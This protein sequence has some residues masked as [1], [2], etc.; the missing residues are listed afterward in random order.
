MQSIYLFQQQTNSPLS[1]FQSAD[2]ANIFSTKIFNGGTEANF[3]RFVVA[4]EEKMYRFPWI[5]TRE[6]HD[7]TKP[8]TIPFSDPSYSSIKRTHN[9]ELKNAW[10]ACDIF[11][12]MLGVEP[13]TCISS[14]R[15]NSLLS[16]REKLLNSLDL[17]EGFYT[18]NL[19]ETKIFFDKLL[20]NLHPISTFDRFDILVSD[21]QQILQ[22]IDRLDRFYQRRFHI[23][24]KMS[25][26]MII[27]LFS[28]KLLGSNFTHARERLQSRVKNEVPKQQERLRS[29]ENFYLRHGRSE[30]EAGA[31]SETEN[32]LL[33]TL[34]MLFRDGKPVPRFEDGALVEQRPPVP[35]QPPPPP[36]F[37]SSSQS[38]V[39]G[40]GSTAA[41]SPGS[42]SPFVDEGD[43]RAREASFS[44]I[45]IRIADAARTRRQERR[46]NWTRLK[47]GLGPDP[48]PLTFF[49]AVQVVRDAMSAHTTKSSLESSS[50][51]ISSNS[52]SS[53]VQPIALVASSQESLAAENARLRFELS[54]RDRS[55][56]RER[57]P[58]TN[59]RSLE[60]G[61]ERSTSPSF[62]GRS[63]ERNESVEKKPRPQDEIKL[64]HEFMAAG[65]CK[66]GDDCRFAHPR[67]HRSSSPHPSARGGGGG[68]G[69]EN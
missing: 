21:F 4:M 64:C 57:S 24:G 55:V 53:S 46:M 19:E 33:V 59:R 56:S 9:D 63:R 66:R 36:P 15:S 28:D 32:D 29:L 12:G 25:E 23:S 44:E 60:R 18:R 7:P 45:H 47:A 65:S 10:E 35:R 58:T 27:S 14:I 42:G 52:S 43:R 11:F 3:I 41:I 54:R 48:A 40:R 20:G 38:P 30:K 6:T 22:H 68:G 13:K 50:S 67:G 61:R 51:T 2:A 16:P 26:T 8:I 37:F 34:Q 1:M 5:F 69:S 39:R 49:E 62:R 17:L 31:E